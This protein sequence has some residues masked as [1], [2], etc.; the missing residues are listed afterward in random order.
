MDDDRIKIFISYAHEDDDLQRRLASHLKILSRCAVWNDR[1]ISGGQEWHDKIMSQL[2]SSDIVVMLISAPFLT[3]DFIRDVEIPHA[4]RLHRDKKARIVPVLGRPVEWYDLELA[5]LQAFPADD[6]WMES[7]H[8]TSIDEAAREVAKSIKTVIAEIDA[9]RQREREKRQAA[10]EDYRREVA[11]ALSDHRISPLERL[12]LEERREQL[13]LS[14]EVADRIEAGE[15]QPIEEK[16]KN[17]KKYEQAIEL[18]IESYGDPFS[19]VARSDLGKRQSKLGLQDEDVAGMAE[20]V[21]QRLEAERLAAMTHAAALR[22]ADPD[23]SADFGLP[24]ERASLP[25]PLPAAPPA[26][27]QLPPAPPVGLADASPVAPPVESLVPLPTS[28]SS[29][30][31][32]AAWANVLGQG[33][34]RALD[35][36]RQRDQLEG[37]HIAPAIPKLLLDHVPRK[38]KVGDTVLVLVDSAD[39]TRR[40]DCL[41]MGPLGVMFTGSALSPGRQFVSYAELIQ[42][43]LEPRDDGD[44]LLVADKRYVNPDLLALSPYDTLTAFELVGRVVALC[45]ALRKVEPGPLSSAE[46]PAMAEHFAN[47]VAR[48]EGLQ[49]ASDAAWQEVWRRALCVVLQQGVTRKWFS[50]GTLQ[51]APEIPAKKLRNAQA[52]MQFPEWDTPFGLFDT[53]VFG[54][55]TDGMLFGTHSMYFHSSGGAMPGAHSLHYSALITDQNGPMSTTGTD[56]ELTN[57]TAL[58]L[59]CADGK[60]ARLLFEALRAMRVD[61]LNTRDAHPG[62]LALAQVQEVVAGL[63]QRARW[64]A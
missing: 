4:L 21:V 34:Q 14:K 16:R 45:H 30:D 1:S 8:W 32:E 11:E 29:A 64:A 41:I 61:Y 23:P 47:E 63:A 35:D 2:T 18:A 46:V 40:S 50:T 5:K 22:Q 3:S 51:V 42:P 24:S 52:A 49:T 48:H 54:S 7:R 20:R 27:A 39:Q 59:G 6:K 58:Y 53:T 19:E 25:P 9:E 62:Y 38:N 33:L 28:A 12:T 26:P 57:S 36:V 56:I 13:E 15:M 44:H 37:L 60:N 10:E 43:D 17:L 31:T 55:A